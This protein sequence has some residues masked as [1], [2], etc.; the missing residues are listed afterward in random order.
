MRRTYRRARHL[1]ARL[2]AAQDEQRLSV[3][4]LAQRL[5]VSPSTAYM[6][7]YGWRAP[8]PKVLR[9]MLHAFPELAQE[10][11]VFLLQDMN[12]SEFRDVL[13]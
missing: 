1:V 6:L 13:R 9:G 12:D 10:V 5:G 4:E 11:H 8:G 3:A 2:R 7:Y